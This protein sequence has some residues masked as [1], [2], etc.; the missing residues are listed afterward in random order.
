MSR[1]PRT[2]AGAPTEPA[3]L[4]RRGQHGAPHRARDCRKEEV[5]ELTDQGSYKH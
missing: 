2:W 1:P 4:V 5:A 3:P